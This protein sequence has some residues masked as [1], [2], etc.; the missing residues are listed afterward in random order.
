[1]AD[2]S[3]FMERRGE[4]LPASGTF[5]L[6]RDAA[7]DVLEG[8]QIAVARC[9]RVTRPDRYVIFTDGSSHSKYKHKSPPVDRP[10]EPPIMCMPT[11]VKH[12]QNCY[13]RPC[14]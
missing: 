12:R 1:M 10:L 14:P 2:Y 3:I 7:L 6:F 4:L 5:E 8:I 11:A 9:R 13:S